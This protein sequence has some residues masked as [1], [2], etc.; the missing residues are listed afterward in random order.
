[1][2]DTRNLFNLFM[3][4]KLRKEP[5]F[6][7]LAYHMENMKN[8]TDQDLVESLGKG[9][10]A[11]FREVYDRYWAVLYLHAH[12]MVQDEAAATDIVQDVFADLWLKTETLQIQYS[13]KAYL[14]QAVR[15][16]T[17]DTMRKSS[18]HDKFLSSLVDFAKEGYSHVDEDLNLR[19]LTE[20]IEAEIELLPPRMRKIFELSR[21]AGKSHHT[22]AEELDITDHTVKKT[23]NR[24]LHILR[25]KIT[26]LSLLCVLA[27][28]VG[29]NRTRKYALNTLL[30][31]NKKEILS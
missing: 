24:V 21:F 23:L 22:I 19:E 6:C 30:S 1:M 15:Y 25:S 10:H 4:A 27:L 17:L 12:K 9:S 31:S 18:H 7:N 14:Y 20:R 28:L 29:I 16:K 5:F 11:A 8:Y 3:K 2:A 13:I 26:F